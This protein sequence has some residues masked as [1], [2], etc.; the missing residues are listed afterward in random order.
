MP[1]YQLFNRLLPMSF[2]VAGRR[3]A[4]ATIPSMRHLDMSSRL[5]KL[6]ALDFRPANILDVG[7][8]NGEWARGAHTIWPAARIVGVEPNAREVPALERTRAEVPHFDFIRG[9]L[10]AEARTVSYVDSETQTSLFAA[11][12]ETPGTPAEA[13]MY[14]LDELLA[15]GRLA[16]PQFV[17]LDVQGYELEVLR[18]AGELLRGVDAVLMEV[19]FAAFLPGM[20]T[21]DDVLPFMLERGF[22]WYDIA[23]AIRRPSDDRLTQID[24]IF[25]RRGHPLLATTSDRFG[26]PGST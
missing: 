1:V 14:V 7:A 2:R 25:I 10:G 9:F 23:G 16:Q 15:S 12:P 18:G 13:P 11:G 21:I 19:T 26:A 20:P 5:A 4:L 8:A 3:A 6:A 24:A 17:K 22:A